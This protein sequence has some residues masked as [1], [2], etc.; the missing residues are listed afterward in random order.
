MK[1]IAGSLVVLALVFAA[2]ACSDSN[3]GTGKIG[4]VA[5]RELPTVYGDILTQRDRAQKAIAKG[6]EMWH[7]EWIQSGS[8]GYI[9]S[10]S[11][12]LLASTSRF[13]WKRR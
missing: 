10:P 5:A 11:N 1:R 12:P 9:S 13:L 3:D 2:G 4:T 7:E 8:G 6:T